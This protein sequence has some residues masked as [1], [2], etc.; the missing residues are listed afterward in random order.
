MRKLGKLLLLICCCWLITGPQLILQLSAWSWMIASY[1]QQSTFEQAIAETF[2]GDY[3]CEICKFIQST[4][5]KTSPT[6]AKES[7]ENKS[8]KLMYEQVTRILTLPNPCQVSNVG[9][10]ELFPPPL[11]YRVPTPPPR[12]V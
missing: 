5:D 1:S 6:P 11:H 3:P 2:S 8:F 7:N 4:D 9:K 12:F 10:S